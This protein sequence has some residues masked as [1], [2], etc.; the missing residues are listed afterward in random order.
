[1]LGGLAGIGQLINP[2]R[3]TDTPKHVAL[4]RRAVVV[5]Q[6]RGV[7]GSGADQ[8]LDIGGVHHAEVSGVMAFNH[9][10]P[11]MSI[12]SWSPVLS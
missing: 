8:H 11:W 3:L 6:P 2:R 9:Y 7:F 4:H 5:G 1:M 12:M 10:G